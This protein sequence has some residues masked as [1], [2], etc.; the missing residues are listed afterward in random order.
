ML[1]KMIDTNILVY[2]LVEGHPATSACEAFIRRVSERKLL[3]TTP[4]T[5]FETYYVLWRVYGLSREKAF[6][7]ADSFFDSPLEFIE[8]TEEDARV[9]LRKVME[10]SLEANDALLLAACLHRGITSLATDDRRLLRACQEEGVHTEEPVDDKVTREMER[11][12]KEKLPEKGAQ[13]LLHRVY[14]W[15]LDVEP[16]V[17]KKFKQA[18]GNMK[19]LP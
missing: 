4:L 14:S 10:H 19:K 1:K 12:E 16:K 2:A 7:Q 13:R 15:L 9:A 17:A 8:I 18:T 3:V 5:A 6:E 11:W